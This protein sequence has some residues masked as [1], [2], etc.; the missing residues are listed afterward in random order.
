M[1]EKENMDQK[2]IKFSLKTIACLLICSLLN[3]SAYA[4]TKSKHASYLP[5]FQAQKKQNTNYHRKGDSHDLWVVLTKSFSLPHYEHTAAV[6]KQIHWFMAH[7]KT[8]EKMA[9][10][11]QPYLYYVLHEV[12]K[13]HMPGELALLPMIESAY[14]PF[15]YSYAGAAGLWQLMPGTATGF[16]LRHDYWF[17]GR[18]DIESSTRAALTY[19]AYLKDFFHGNWN[20]AIA[21][22][23]SG[24]GTV[25][26]AI[27]RNRRRGLSTKF[28][29][30][31]LP[32]QTE[33]Y[34][35]RLLALATIISE[36]GKYP[37]KLPYIL[38]K[39]YFA[40]VKIKKQTSLHKIAKQAH[41]KLDDLYQLNP[42]F[43]RWATDP[44]KRSPQRVLLP[45][46]KVALYTGK[47][48][49]QSKA[50]SSTTDNSQYTVQSGD[51][52]GSISDQ[53]DTDVDSLRS[54]NHIHGS[55]IKVNQV[56]MIPAHEKPSAKDK[57]TVPN[58][59]STSTSTSSNLQSLGTKSS[60][61]KAKQEGTN[62]KIPA[63]ADKEAKSQKPAEQGKAISAKQKTPTKQPTN[64][65]TVKHGDSLWSI[66][67]HFNT[68]VQELSNWNHLHHSG[69]KPGTKLVIK[70][71]HHSSHG[72]VSSNRL[73]HHAQTVHYQVKSG[74]TLSKIARHHHISLKKLLSANHLSS[75]SMIKPGEHLVIPS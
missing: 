11:A 53:F 42:G 31:Y 69:L 9:S 55:L 35:P 49:H 50:Q 60:V 2:I 65:Y 17:D 41:M 12:R 27:K 61:D 25:L 6:K 30:L 54:M 70:A 71:P 74:D 73:K 28:W 47:P 68:T 22:Y 5:Y 64:T 29:S 26:N 46:T 72:Q 34:V 14:D 3:I 38:N 15:A 19:L 48:I 56:I 16:G 44:D 63:A 10:Q 24:E 23:N 59:T 18:K 8:I 1:Q 39:P 45:V 62:K 51:T 13:R 43:R 20:L 7:P 40:E 32:R 21:S 67:Q 57:I 37:V 4:H 58:N 75:R 52:L 66:A 36:P 33:D